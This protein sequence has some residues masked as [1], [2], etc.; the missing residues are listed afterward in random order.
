MKALLISFVLLGLIFNGF[1]QD[2]EGNVDICSVLLQE[3][4][5]KPFISDGQVYSAFLDRGEKAEF[6]TTFFGGTTYRIS[7]SAGADEN[8]VIF[9]IK[10][11]DGN[12][13]FSNENYNNAPY[14]DFIVDESIALTIE[15]R[16]DPELK[17]TGCLAMLIGFR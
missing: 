3:N 12:I 9:K 16:L 4:T 8:Y 15:V 1:S 7:S 17:L 11:P 5:E 10:D 14:W 13:L 6:K 2:C